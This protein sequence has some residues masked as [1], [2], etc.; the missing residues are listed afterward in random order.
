MM[1]HSILLIAHSDVSS[2]DPSRRRHPRWSAAADPSE[3]G[4]GPKLRS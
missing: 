2:L 3:A 1:S 4:A